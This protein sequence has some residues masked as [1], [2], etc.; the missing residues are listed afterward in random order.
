MRKIFGSAI[1]GTRSNNE[2]FG[3][4][5]KRAASQQYVHGLYKGNVCYRTGKKPQD[6]LMA[7]GNIIG[8]KPGGSG[9]QLA[10]PPIP[11]GERA[12]GSRCLV[13]RGPRRA[14]LPIPT[15]GP[16]LAA[17]ARMGVAGNAAPQPVENAAGRLRAYRDWCRGRRCGRRQESRLLKG[18]GLDW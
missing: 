5:H 15:G 7:S 2:V 16:L 10:L 1:L 17:A 6:A 18:L 4:M 14:L 3:L 8:G 11:A 13:A 9:P 12:N